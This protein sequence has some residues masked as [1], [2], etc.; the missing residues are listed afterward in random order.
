VETPSKIYLNV[1]YD[2]KDRAKAAGARWDQRQRSWFV[3][4]PCELAP[5]ARWLPRWA[6]DPGA[7]VCLPV[8]LLPTTC[9]RCRRG[10]TCA[11]GLR[12]PEECDVEPSGSV[13]DVAFIAVDDCPDVLGLLLA[14]VVGPSLCMGPLLFRKTRPRPD[15]YL[16]NTCW[17]CGATQGAFP[18]WEE[19]LAFIDGDPGQIPL[20]W[21]DGLRVDYPVAALPRWTR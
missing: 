11:V 3:S 14:P 18:L 19:L 1:P 15:G 12:I 8:L 7:T 16:A 13:G 20:L 2:E 17:H 9:Y 4:A 21:S 10:I 5:V 6:L